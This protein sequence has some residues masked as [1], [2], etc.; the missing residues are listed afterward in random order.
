MD[1]CTKLYVMMGRVY[2]NQG[3]YEKANTEFTIAQELDTAEASFI[4]PYL[5]EVHFLT[6]NY[7][8]VYSMMNMAKNLEFNATLQ[9]IAEQW[10]AS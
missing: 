3:K 6:G 8:V 5:A 10:K 2:M 4:L 1:V 7:D 9:P